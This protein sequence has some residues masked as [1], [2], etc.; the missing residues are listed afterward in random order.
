MLLKIRYFAMPAAA[1]TLVM[2]PPPA[3]ADAVSDFYKGNRVT[4]VV[5]VPPGGGYDLNARVLA[6]HMER[7]IPGNPA[8]IVQNMPGAGGAKAAN[9]MSNVAP[10]NGTMIGMPLSSII[11]AQLLRPGKVKYD[12]NKFNWLGTITT[13][14]LS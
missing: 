7:H 6:R 13:D 14:T 2:A 12:A 9:H 4:F 10:R 8:T 3:G 1:L 5:A 11:V